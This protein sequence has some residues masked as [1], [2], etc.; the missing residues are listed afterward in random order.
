MVEDLGTNSARFPQPIY[1]KEGFSPKHHLKQ[2]SRC[3]NSSTQ[4]LATQRLALRKDE[5]SMF[6]C[7]SAICSA[8]KTGRD[9]GAGQAITRHRSFF[10]L[11][12]RTMKNKFLLF[13]R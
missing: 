7:G 1:F 12:S 3:T 5:Y 9:L 10:E 2:V 6:L 13:T 4:Q 11:A 8:L